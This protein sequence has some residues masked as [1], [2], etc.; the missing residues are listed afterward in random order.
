VTSLLTTLT[1]QNA[2]SAFAYDES[3]PF[4]AAS[5]SAGMNAANDVVL[6]ELPQR[7]DSLVIAKI[8]LWVANQA[9]NL[10]VGLWRFDGATWTLITSSGS[11]AVGTGAAV[12]TV[13]LLAPYT[14]PPRT[15]TYI[16]LS[17]D[18]G[19]ATFGRAPG[20]L[21]LGLADFSLVGKA[22]SF[23]LATN[24]AS[25]GTGAVAANSRPYWLRAVTT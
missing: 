12:Q 16:G 6:M 11:T 24:A 13:T 5:N 22:T 18:S 21:L 14:R 4:A 15:R 3:V 25:F 7:N 2:G 1:R 19:T 8:R 17:T 9:G 23:P 20:L 10:D